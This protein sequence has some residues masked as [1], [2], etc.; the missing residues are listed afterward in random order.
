MKPSSCL[1][2]KGSSHFFLCSP[3]YCDTIPLLTAVITHLQHTVCLHI[4]NELPTQPSSSLFGTSSPQ[5]LMTSPSCAYYGSIQGTFNDRMIWTQI[6]FFLLTSPGFYH[7]LML[8]T[9]QLLPWRMSL[10]LR[11]LTRGNCKLCDRQGIRSLWGD[12]LRLVSV[13]MRNQEFLDTSRVPYIH[14]FILWDTQI[15]SWW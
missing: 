7:S 3:V 14:I 11:S 15:S 10:L 2:L 12:S 13:P 5:W 8:I 4:F 6:N 1:C 9:L